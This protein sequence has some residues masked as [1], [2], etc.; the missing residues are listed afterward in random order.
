MEKKRDEDEM[1]MWEDEYSEKFDL[2]GE[3][4]WRRNEDVRRGNQCEDATAN[5]PRTAGHY[6]ANNSLG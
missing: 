6:F 3:E 2:N 5:W 4:W 1:R